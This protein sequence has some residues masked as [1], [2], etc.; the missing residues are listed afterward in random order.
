MG[1]DRRFA[2]GLFENMPRLKCSSQKS[3]IALQVFQQISATNAQSLSTKAVGKMRVV[4][5]CQHS[6]VEYRFQY[7]L[8]RRRPSFI[9]WLPQRL[10]NP[11]QRQMV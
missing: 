9:Q 4:P 7:S 5:N 6:S 2:A 1:V 11:Q 8:Q 3:P 10:S